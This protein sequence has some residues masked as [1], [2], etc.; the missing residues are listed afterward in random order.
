MNNVSTKDVI[1]VIGWQVGLLAV[2]VLLFV[3]DN[4]LA[5]GSVAAV[6]N[7][8]SATTPVL[9]VAPLNVTSIPNPA[10]TPSSTSTPN[11]APPP[12]PA[13]SA[14]A[15]PLLSISG[16]VQTDWANVRSGPGTSYDPVGVLQ[17]DSLVV[18]L[19]QNSDSTWA[20]IDSPRGWISL[21]VLKLDGPLDHI[22]IRS[23]P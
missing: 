17:R 10:P 21:S 1:K 20:Y 22:P 7:P 11:P 16:V 8:P 14:T 15:E 6:L 4:L 19:E 13:S 12:S 3:T 18:I 2:G 23:V 9:Q 5:L